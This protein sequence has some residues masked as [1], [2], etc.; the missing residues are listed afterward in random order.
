MLQN[1]K[2]RYFFPKMSFTRCEPEKMTNCVA[3]WPFIPP[4]LEE[5]MICILLIANKIGGGG[6]GEVIDSVLSQRD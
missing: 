3:S 4:W 6:E 1:V 2:I 5:Y